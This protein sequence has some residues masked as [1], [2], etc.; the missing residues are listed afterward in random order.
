MQ[1]LFFLAAALSIGAG[2][3][4][5]PAPAAR[6]LDTRT[7]H[8]HGCAAGIEC[9]SDEDCRMNSDCTQ[10]AQGKPNNIHCGQENYPF[11]CWAEWNT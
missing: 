3:L 11:A 9:H 10:T 7:Y 4:A 5:S 1:F 8:W 2:T 6:S